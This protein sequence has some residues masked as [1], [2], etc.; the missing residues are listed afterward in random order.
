MDALGDLD[1]YDM[2]VP[3]DVTISVNAMCNLF[4]HSLI[5]RL[6]WTCEDLSQSDCVTQYQAS[7]Q[8]NETPVKFTGPLFAS[9]KSSTKQLTLVKVAELVR[10]FRVCANDEVTRLVGRRDDRG[11]IHVTAL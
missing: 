8:Y 10:I 6:V 2:D 3:K 9:D 11:R 5:L 4:V 1:M 7:P